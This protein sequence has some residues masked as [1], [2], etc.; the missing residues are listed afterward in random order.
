[1]KNTT[2]AERERLIGIYME[3]G[4]T[5]REAMA[6]LDNVEAE[7]DAVI[8]VDKDGK[9]REQPTTQLFED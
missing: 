1:M 3:Q 9:T 6:A 4:L 5:R 7:A 2:K 8:Q